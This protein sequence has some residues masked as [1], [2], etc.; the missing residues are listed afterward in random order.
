MPFIHVIEPDSA[1]GK[2]ARIYGL[3][4][5]PGGQV[6]HVLQI[7]SLRPHSLEG[8]MALYKAVLHHPG[9]RLPVWFLEAIG[10]LVS[11][12]NRCD[13]C[14]RHHLAGMKRLLKSDPEKFRACE[15]ALSVGEGCHPCQ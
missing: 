10:V 7:H 2:L 13:Y 4:S 15:K 12:L 5:G 14:A 8:H 1:S 3:V 11:R 6:D 9:N